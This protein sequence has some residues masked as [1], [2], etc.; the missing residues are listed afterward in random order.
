MDAK[1]VSKKGILA[2]GNFDSNEGYA[3]RLM[4]RFWCELSL[5]GADQGYQ[6]Y[7]CFPTVT[8]VPQCLTDAS[9]RVDK[10][11]FTVSGL[12]ALFK[13][14][15]YIIKNSIHVMY[16][17][18]LKTYSWRYLL[19]RLAGVK[20]IVVHDHTPGMRSI[21]SGLKGFLK[22]FLNQMPFLSCTAAL[23]VSPYVADR[24]V[25]VNGLP[26]SK[27][28]CVTNGIDIGEALSPV[29]KSETSALVRVVTVG[30]VCF[31]KGIDFA[32][33]VI[34]VL[35]KDY[36]LNNFEY[37]VIGDGPDI[38]DF[39]HRVRQ[40]NLGERVHFIGNV[41]NV[42][43][44]LL[45]CDIAFH[46]SRGEAMSLA[47][48]EYMRAG[49]AVVASDNPSVSSALEHD[50]YAVIYRQE[51]VQSAALTLKQLI[52]EPETRF[53]LGAGAQREVAENFSSDVM[54]RKFRDVM[55]R[56]VG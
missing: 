10:V 18:D 9:C 3:W 26:S 50:E 13:Q 12:S 11:D 4:E 49:L 7:V 2:V 43:E 38:D 23:A 34:N 20:T 17:T 45:S 41:A 42:P 27:V 5:L 6:T 47:I 15:R 56:F 51:D 22:R 14:V 31:Y 53:R 29:H 54:L 19:F 21:P 16:L 24:L 28:F 35:V 33:D 25:S 44:R 48:L 1:Q 36:S 37:L 52:E 8:V 32:I 40:L 46:P 55:K 30:R 39:K